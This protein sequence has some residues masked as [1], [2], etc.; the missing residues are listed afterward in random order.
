MASILAQILAVTSVALI[1]IGHA[2]Q[3]E[4][5]QIGAST[6]PA[7]VALAALA[8][9]AHPRSEAIVAAPQPVWL[10]SAASAVDPASDLAAEPS[11]PDVDPFL[12]Y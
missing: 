6:D 2:A 11:A 7:A 1:L 4:C 5:R 8:Q 12:L 9:L 10:A 3:G